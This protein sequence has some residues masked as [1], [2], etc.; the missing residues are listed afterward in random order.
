MSTPLDEQQITVSASSLRAMRDEFQRFLMEYRFG[1]QEIETKISILRE[2]FHEMHDYN[3]IEH[4]SSRVKSPD[5]IVEK[6]Q[7]RGI[8][9][10]FDSVRAHITDI[11]GIRITCSFVSDV[12]RLFDLLTAQDD[13][14][15]REVEDYIATPK[16]NGY[17]SL[18]TILEVPVYLSTG[19]VDVPVEVQ[20]R[21][22]A[23]DFWASLEHKIYYKYERQVPEHLLG[24]LKD[25]ADAAA[26]L[27]ARMA[28]LHQQ[29]RGGAAV[30]PTRLV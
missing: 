22:I 25:A 11:A 21:T 3:P 24:Q 10:D 6:I 26:E 23:M 7:R 16:G 2:E 19:R 15:V 28:R 4:V 17:K 18:H 8:E 1:L 14:T 30:A 9:P 12:Y 13:I 27:D 5:S 20:F 29:I